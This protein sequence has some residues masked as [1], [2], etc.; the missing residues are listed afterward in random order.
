MRRLKPW[1]LSRVGLR[2]NYVQPHV[3]SVLPTPESPTRASKGISRFGQAVFK[4][5]APPGI[6]DGTLPSCELLV[7][8]GQEF[9]GLEGITH[10]CDGVGLG[11]N[12]G[13]ECAQG[14]AETYPCVWDDS[15]SL[16]IINPPLTCSSE[17]SLASVPPASASHD[18]D[19]L[20]LQ[21]ECTAICAESFEA[22]S[23]ATALTAQICHF[24]GYTYADT[25]LQF[26]SCV[27][28]TLSQRSDSSTA[29]TEKFDALD[30]TNSTVGG[31]CIV[32]CATGYKLASGDSLRTLTCVSE[33]ESVACLT[34]SLPACHVTRCLNST[35]AVPSG[36]SGDCES[37]THGASCQVACQRISFPCTRGKA[38]QSYFPTGRWRGRRAQ[39]GWHTQSRLQ[40]P[41][42]DSSM[43]APDCPDSTSGNQF[44]AMCAALHGQRQYLDLQP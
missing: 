37:I 1:P 35:S 39:C 34:G 10:T 16:K 26:S 3:H 4:C 14:V 33:N 19:G 31:T 36:V 15:T 32:G 13:A 29:Q 12:C 41:T 17:C 21:E 28:T 24:G 7:C 20:A 18:C 2:W 25:G 40:R 9:D 30:C 6:P 44:N 22:K 42:P 27:T 38:A 8:L 5:L 11:D 23:S 43:S